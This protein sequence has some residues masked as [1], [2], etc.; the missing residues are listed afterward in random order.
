MKNTR[1]KGSRFERYL[2]ERLKEIDG[3]AKRNFMSGQRLDKG[4]IRM[5]SL[6]FNIEAKNAKTV[7]LVKDFQQTEKQCVSGGRPVLIIRNPKK[8]EFQQSYVVMD[9][10]DWLELAGGHITGGTHLEK[11]VLWKFNQL[12]NSLREVEKIVKKLI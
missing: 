5:P 10:E 8:S 4:D 7:S 11:S 1:K 6:D 12:K 3:Q 2:V 9:L